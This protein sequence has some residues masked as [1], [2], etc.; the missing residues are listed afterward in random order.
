LRD[1]PGREVRYGNALL[2]RHPIVQQRRCRFSDLSECDASA[3]IDDLPRATLVAPWSWLSHEPRG[4]VF[5]DFR[6]RGR[7]VRAIVTHLDPFSAQARETQA[8]QIVAGLV[9]REGSVVLLGDMNS[10]PTPLTLDRQWFSADRTHDVLTSGRLFDLRGE[11]AGD[12]PSK[13]E[14]WATYP[15]D[16]PRWGLD[17]VFASADLTTATLDVFGQG[18][19]D[20]LGLVGTLVPITDTA[21]LTERQ[22]RH[23]LRRKSRFERLERC[24]LPDR[25]ESSFFSWLRNVSGTMDVAQPASVAKRATTDGEQPAAVARSTTPDVETAARSDGR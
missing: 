10:V 16:G 19:S 4:V 6:W 1:T 20:H 14:R 3:T 13:W 17:G 25:S 9:P 2:V 18:L 15:V 23:A 7:D 21:R 24:D 8:A 5:A 22:K 12:D 11:L